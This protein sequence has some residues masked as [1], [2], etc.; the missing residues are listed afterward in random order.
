MPQQ[1]PRMG[2]KPR[3]GKAWLYDP[4]KSSK[5]M[6]ALQVHQAVSANEPAWQ[7]FDNPLSVHFHFRFKRPKSVRRRHHSIKPDLSNLI[8]YYEDAF[9]GVIWKDD[10]LITS[11]KATKSYAAKD[12][13][14]GIDIMVWDLKKPVVSTQ[15]V[16]KHDSS[17]TEPEQGPSSSSVATTN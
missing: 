15:P 8:K 6:L 5:S 12:E 2:Q 9:N 11:I 13:E 3:L 1:R 14:G 17:D 10:A 4:D 16:S 7:P